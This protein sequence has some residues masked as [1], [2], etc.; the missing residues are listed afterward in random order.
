MKHTCR[1]LTLGVAVLIAGC[2]GENGTEPL[3]PASISIVLAKLVLAAVGET[4][5]AS[6]RV[7]D[8]NGSVLGGQTV[9]WSSSN[10][11]VAE[12]SATGLVTARGE[13]SAVISASVGSVSG[14]VI[15]RIEQVV[16]GLVKTTGD[17]QT[18][19]VGQPLSLS[20]HGRLTDAN[21]SPVPRRSVQCPIT[22]GGG[23]PRNQAGSGARGPVSV[24][25]G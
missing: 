17:N 9:T 4:T 2:K 20:P 19:A 16:T 14:S 15:V 18:G 10:T 11:P 3:T 7:L 25:G 21:G 12:V 8:Q 13:G 5:Q 24:D 22:A 23:S 1:I 6:A